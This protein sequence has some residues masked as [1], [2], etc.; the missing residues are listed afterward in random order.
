MSRPF[1]I[2]IAG[3]GSSSGKTGLACAI[4]E[5]LARTGP[6]GAVKIAT[7]TPDKICE[8]SGLPCS[9][10]M[11]DGRMRILEKECVDDR[12]GKD[13]WRL[14]RAGANPVWFVQTTRDI[15][16]ETAGAVIDRWSATPIVVIEGAGP[17]RAGLAD[18]AVLVAPQPGVVPKE[19][20]LDGLDGKLDAVLTPARDHAPSLRVTPPYVGE[21]GPI[22]GPRP[23]DDFW[24]ALRRQS[25]PPD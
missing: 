18:F 4:V 16:L 1:V 24:S 17:I 22:D 20:W 12:E 14:G 2:A 5:E 15:A 21:L 11:F 8:R 19:G 25:I 10:L 13:T 9:C 7:A 3:P 6:V 23:H